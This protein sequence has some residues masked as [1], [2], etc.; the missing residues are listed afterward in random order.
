MFAEAINKISKRKPQNELT[1]IEIVTLTQ[2]LVKNLNARINTTIQK[3]NNTKNETKDIKT[4]SL[5][6]SN[7]NDQAAESKQ[8]KLQFSNIRDD[9]NLDNE[10][11]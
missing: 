10:E 7:V 2:F 1:T 9:S 8:R 3:F 11:I 5:I 4:R 6:N